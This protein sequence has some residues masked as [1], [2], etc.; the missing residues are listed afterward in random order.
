MTDDTAPEPA[1][2]WLDA[3]QQT[4]WRGLLAIVSRAFPEF[5]RTLKAHDLLA[6]HYQIF[7]ALSEAPDRPLRLRALL[8]PRLSA[9]AGWSGTQWNRS[10]R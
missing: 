5:E 2:R 8:R 10:R 9:P 3:T 6:V 1:P 4:A 7:A